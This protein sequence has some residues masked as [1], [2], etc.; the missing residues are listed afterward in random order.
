VVGL[1]KF[2]TPCPSY[3]RREVFEFVFIIPRL[4]KAGLGVVD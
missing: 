1:V 4:R 3:F 2:T